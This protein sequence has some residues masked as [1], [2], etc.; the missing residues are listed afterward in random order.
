MARR[1][2]ADRMNGF[3]D[4]SFEREGEITSVNER[5]YVVTDESIRSNLRLERPEEE[6]SI[7]ATRD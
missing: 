7:Q 3:L 1:R 6:T 4:R 2:E 5:D